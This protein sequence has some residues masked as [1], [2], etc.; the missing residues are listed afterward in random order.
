MENAGETGKHNW[1]NSQENR[2]NEPYADYQGKRRIKK[3]ERNYPE[4]TGPRP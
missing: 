2:A 4:R 3:P 1:R